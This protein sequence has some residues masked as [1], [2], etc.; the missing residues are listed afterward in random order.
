ML[1]T[2]VTT[3]YNSSDHLNEFHRR[4]STLSD[5]ISASWEFVFVNDG[6][7]DNSLEIALELAV[8]DPR[9]V[10]ID[11]AR[12]FGHHKAMMAGLAHATGDLIFLLDCDLEEEPEWLPS[13]F[14]VMQ[15]ERADVVYGVQR[16]RKG[17]WVE[18]TSG[19]LFWW[20]IIHL[21]QLPI[22]PNLVTARLMTR[23][24]VDALLTHRE[25]EVFIAGLWAITGFKQLP[26][27][28][29]K[30][31]RGTSSYNLARRFAL[32]VNAITSFSN[33]PLH[34]I[35]YLGSIIT[36]IATIAAVVMIARKLMFGE[37]LAGW[38]S[39]IVSIWLLSGVIIFSIGILGIYLAKIFAEVK[40]RPNIIIRA[41]HRRD[42]AR[43][44][45]T[46]KEH[47]NAE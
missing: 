47:Q 15:Q 16:N 13:F 10:I 9:L 39:I 37:L 1:I 41:I 19:R 7:P 21:S 33:R 22:P 35:F 38:A 17:G 26:L 42:A 4:I 40:H 34:L 18:R 12:N 23:Q 20:M 44:S 6:S 36:L 25:H 28:V 45:M 11:L 46:L 31:S 43:P 3:L 32:A 2:V 5:S 30:H 8:N 24:Y 14:S 27:A 29:D